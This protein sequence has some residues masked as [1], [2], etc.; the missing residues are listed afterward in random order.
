M[1]ICVGYFVT[2]VLNLFFWF[3]PIMFGFSDTEKYIHLHMVVLDLCTD[4][5]LVIVVIATEGY[6][7]HWWI[8]VD[9]AFKLIMV[10]RTI[11]FHCFLNLILRKKELDTLQKMQSEQLQ[12][13]NK[14]FDQGMLFFICLIYKFYVDYVKIIKGAT[15]EEI[16]LQTKE[17]IK[18]QTRELEG[19]N[20]NKSN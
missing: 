14:L 5:P 9:I 10:L 18:N 8:F 20:G 4:L 3:F 19:G 7:I 6:D 1:G 15:N 11:A 2:L 17:L 12:L 16:E 13:E